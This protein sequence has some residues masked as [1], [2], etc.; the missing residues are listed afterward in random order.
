MLSKKRKARIAYNKGKRA[1][2]NWQRQRNRIV[3]RLCGGLTR[4]QTVLSIKHMLD[5]DEREAVKA[6]MHAEDQRILGEVA[7]IEAMSREEFY[8]FRRTIHLTE[9]LLSV[10]L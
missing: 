2:I 9:P 4:T 3:N 6:R 7:R 1:R 5:K 10:A 8:Q